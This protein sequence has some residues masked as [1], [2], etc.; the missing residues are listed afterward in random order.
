MIFNVVTANFRAVLVSKDAGGG[1]SGKSEEEKIFWD[2]DRS[3]YRLEVDAFYVS[4]SS[5]EKRVNW[6]AAVF[7]YPSK[8][9]F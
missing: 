6:F 4:Q 9:T 5:F 2:I 7:K 3:D 8:K 1:V